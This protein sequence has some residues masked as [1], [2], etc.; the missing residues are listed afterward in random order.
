M[1]FPCTEVR[2]TGQ[3]FLGLFLG[4]SFLPFLKV[5][6]T[7]PFFQPQEASPDGHDLEYTLF[8]LSLQHQ[9]LIF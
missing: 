4:L 1:I 2:L 7:L 5:N 9:F 3:K 8:M 6:V